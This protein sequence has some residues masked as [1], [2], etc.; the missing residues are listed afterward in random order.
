MTYIAHQP[1]VDVTID[2]SPELFD[3]GIPRSVVLGDSLNRPVKIAEATWNVLSPHNVDFGALGSGL[4]V[5]IDPWT[6]WQQNT[7]VKEK[8]KHFAYFRCNLKVRIVPSCSP[9]HYGTLMCN[10][11]PYSQLSEVFQ[12]AYNILRVNPAAA[13]NEAYIQYMSSYPITAWLEASK[14]NVIE[15]DLPF[16]YNENFLPVAG[17][18][19]SAYYS[20][21]ELVFNVVNILGAANPSTTTSAKFAVFCHAE[22]IELHVPTQL[23]QTSGSTRFPK[24]TELEESQDGIVSTTASAVA[25]FSS[26]LEMVPFI[27]KFAKATTIGASS[28]GNIAKLFGFS[29]PPT[30]KTAQPMVLRL[31]RN[32]ANTTCEDTAQKLSLD[33]SQELTI[34][35]RVTGLSPRDEM[36]FKAIAEREQWLLKAKWLGPT[37]QFTTGFATHPVSEMIM[38]ARV[39]PVAVRRTANF[40]TTPDKFVYQVNPAGHLSRTFRYWRATLVYKIKVVCSRFHRGAL[41][42]T[43]DPLV[44]AGARIEDDVYCTDVNLRKSVVLNIEEADE[45]EI[46]IPYVH[47]RVMMRVPVLNSSSFIPDAYSD[48]AFNL[49]ADYSDQTSI[50]VLAVQVLNELT[51]P[52]DTSG[53]PGTL[54]GVDV[55]LFMRVEDLCLGQPTGGWEDDL[56]TPTSG[57]VSENRISILE[58]ET[59]TD[60]L[61]VMGES[62]SSIRTLMKRPMVVFSGSQTTSLSGTLGTLTTFFFPHFAPE[63]VRSTGV[64]R[65]MCYESYFSPCYLLKRGGTRWRHQI[66]GGNN[67]QSSATGMAQ[68]E[69]RASDVTVAGVPTSVSFAAPGPGN[70]ALINLASGA[71]G[72]QTTTLSYSPVIDVECPFYS[73]TRFNLAGAITNFTD[74][75]N[76]VL[77]PTMVQ[78]LYQRLL[79]QG[80]ASEASFVNSHF[81]T[82]EDYACFMYLSPPSIYRFV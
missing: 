7:F 2:N 42:I 77:N 48:T 17:I 1:E 37:G 71:D 68:I 69:R 41:L 25:D 49:M 14:N 56:Y 70:T 35:P 15:F 8:M 21:G 76:L 64:G 62:I 82:A 81:S 28:I 38:A 26:K 32:L 36:S 58:G 9:F 78:I 29:N 55:N 39:N 67:R 16:V 57:T 46:R 4:S 72:M 23:T 20:L 3:T 54:A 34:D 11:V 45:V 31:Y 50:G 22:Q 27:G 60:L 43:F 24:S 6:L 59:N 30:V 18:D 44:K 12:S 73:S 66:W 33:P 65:R 53:P 52:G 51:A 61:T 40:G 80:V 13:A 10:Y 63:T 19:A 47:H 74:A 75:A 79:I 5:K